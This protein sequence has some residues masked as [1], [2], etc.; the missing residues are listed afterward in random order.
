MQTTPIYPS[1]VDSLWAAK[2]HSRIARNIFLV[3]AGTALLA[4]TA[5]I[6]VPMYPVPMTM[7]T[8][9]VLL[10]G[11]T[12]GWRLAGATVVAYITEGAVGLPVFASGGG[13]AYLAGPTAGYLFGFLAAT[14]IVGW[15]AGRGWDRSFAATFG[16]ALIGS[17]VIYGIGVPWLASFIGLEK[18][19]G[20]GM[21][22]FLLGDLMKAALA[23]ATLPIA[24]KIL[25][26]T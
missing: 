26:R 22:P 16:A 6:Q 13:L 11:M 8:F 2:S 19:I 3:L 24:W 15:L 1:L 14:I 17:A 4:V 18:A 23:T 20:A 7:Q 21:L 5:R 9:S 10:I 12:F 25:Q